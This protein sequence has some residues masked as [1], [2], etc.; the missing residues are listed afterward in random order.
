LEVSLDRRPARLQ[1]GVTVEEV[2]ILIDY[3]VFA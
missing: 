1:G 3:G 2:E